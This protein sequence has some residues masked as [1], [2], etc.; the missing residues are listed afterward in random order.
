MFREAQT[1]RHGHRHVI[2][3][4]SDDEALEQPS[5]EYDNEEQTREQ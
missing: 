2:I 5:E 3:Y 1:I 4:F